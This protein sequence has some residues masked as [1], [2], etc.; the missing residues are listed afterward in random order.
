MEEVVTGSM[1]YWYPSQR[2]NALAEGKTIGSMTSYLLDVFFSKETMSVSNLN[3]RGYCGYKQLCPKT[4]HAITG[5]F[6]YTF[7]ISEA[8][9]GTPPSTVHL[10]V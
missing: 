2:L 9:Q 3:G 1:V 7:Q 5:V 4:V 8:R 6:I 10:C